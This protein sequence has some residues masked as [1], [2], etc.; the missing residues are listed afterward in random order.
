MT[1]LSLIAKVTLV[2]LVSLVAVQLAR[3]ASASCRS[4]ILTS[5]FSVL[6]TLPIV[7]AALSPVAIGVPVLP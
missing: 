1:E 7:S 4:L 5:A 6:L 2:L 3:R